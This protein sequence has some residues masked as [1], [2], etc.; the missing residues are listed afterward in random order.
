MLMFKR[1]VFV[2]AVAASLPGCS[3]LNWFRGD[4]DNTE[5]TATSAPADSP[6]KN[7]WGP[8]TRPATHAGV[9]PWVACL[10][11][12]ASAAPSSGD[13]VHLHSL[14]IWSVEDDGDATL[15]ERFD[16]EGGDRRFDGKVYTRGIGTWFTSVVSPGGFSFGSPGVIFSV[17]AQ[18]Q[19]GY[20]GWPSIWPRKT[21]PSNMHHA[22][23][24]ATFQCFGNAVFQFGADFY[25]APDT[26]ITVEPP[27]EVVEAL[28]SS[29][30]S[31]ADGRITA[32]A[33]F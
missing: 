4:D 23:A 1:F 26:V 9:L 20:H 8:V 13:V 2:L 31:S 18:P 3:I 22:A 24:K 25:P 5:P 12:D 29:W 19:Y 27:P 14:E 17:G 33:G 15:L 6:K 11:R 21:T 16:Y 10:V 30:Y 28:A 7:G 32:S